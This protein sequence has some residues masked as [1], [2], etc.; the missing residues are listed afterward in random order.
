MADHNHDI[1]Y[2]LVVLILAFFVITLS[3]NNVETG[4][5]GNVVKSTSGA[6]GYVVKFLISTAQ[7]AN[8]NAIKDGVITPINIRIVKLPWDALFA[9]NNNFGGQAVHQPSS[10]KNCEWINVENEDYTQ[11]RTLSG[12][13]ACQVKGYDSCL[14]TNFIKT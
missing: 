1:H 2:M 3:F 6:E 13:V 8:I 9:E 12:N 11:I 4:A 7:S 10:M 14:M 5:S